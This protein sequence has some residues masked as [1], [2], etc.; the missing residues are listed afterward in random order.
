M[1]VALV[2]TSVICSPSI[3]MAES[4]KTGPPVPSIRSAPSN[5]FMSY[6]ACG[7]LVEIYLQAGQMLVKA[8]GRVKRW[9]SACFP[10]IR[11]LVQG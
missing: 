6:L 7:V 8:S 1:T 2:P 4:F 3:N 11:L 5:A 9:Q 10:P